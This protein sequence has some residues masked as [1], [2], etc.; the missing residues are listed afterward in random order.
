MERGVGYY[1]DAAL[2]SLGS[3]SAS[4]V[5]TVIGLIL[6]VVATG[7]LTVVMGQAVLGRRVTA[8]EAWARTRPRFWPLLGLTLLVTLITAGVAVGG[9]GVAVLLGLLVGNLT[10]A[11]F[12]VLLG[13]LIG[14]AA[15]LAAGWLYIKLLLAPVALVL[16]SARVTQSMARSWALVRGAWW[17]TFGIYLLGTILAGIVSSVL[18]IPF[19]VVGAVLSFG[20]L[21]EGDVLPLG[22]TISISLATL[23]SSIVVLP[24]SA[25]IVSLL[26]IDRRIRREALDIELARAAGVDL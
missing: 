20:A 25:G 1:L 21:S 16:E 2:S 22:Y 17:R 26:Y 4:L 18:T 8:S 15:L 24:F 3:L 14:I 23:V 10:D 5:Q 11:G 12:G 6:G 7:L 9:L 13:V 19:T